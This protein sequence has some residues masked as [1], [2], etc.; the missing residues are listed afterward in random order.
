MTESEKEVS[1]ELAD[2][3]VEWRENFNNGEKTLEL[4]DKMIPLLEK[5]SGEKAKELLDLKQYIVKKSNWMFGGDGW[6][7]DIGYG[8]LDHV[9]ASGDDVNILVLDTE[10]YSNTGG[11][12]SKS[13]PAGSVA[14]F[15]SS[16]KPVKK[17]DLAAISMTYRNIYVARISMGANQN[18]ALKAIKEAEAYPGPSLIIAYSPGINHGLK[19][20][21]GSSQLETKKAVEC[22]YWAMYRFN[23][24]LKE[25]GENPFI[26]DSKE[27]TAD[28]HE[29]LMGEVRY[30]S[31]KK[32]YPDTAEAL[33][34]KTKA[35]ALERLGNYKRLAGKE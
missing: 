5:E 26:L 10:V 4:R 16:G 22:G 9:L 33:F 18:Q 19:S 12:A 7:Y 15:A 27:P 6:A 24:A 34:A 23:P 29:F 31:L 35:D 28:F 8:G 32:Q 13:T 30:A 20:G 14:K 3:F 25:K 17:K 2:L 1:P 21:M 11:Q